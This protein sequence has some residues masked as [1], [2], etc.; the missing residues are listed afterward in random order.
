MRAL[1]PVVLA[2][3]IAAPAQAA[4]VGHRVERLT[5][6]GAATGEARD[7]PVHLWYPADATSA[8]ARPLTTYTSA[9]NGRPVIGGKTPLSW[10]ID[11]ELA[12]EGATVDP[13]GAP[14]RVV[15]F[16]HGSV[17]DPIDYAHTLE[18]VAAAGFIVAAPYH[19]NNSQEDVRIDFANNNGA[20]PRIPC[21]DGRPSP[22]SRPD[23][24]LSIADRVHDISAIIDALPTWFGA[25][26]D[27]AKV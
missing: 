7:I 17:N 4:P 8:V 2:L 25:R 9:L 3:A 13:A 23:V 5:V 20:S 18:G 21:N 1:A 26:A 22:C 27:L 15:V 16:S 14:F 6:A 11:A 10:R 24:A 19:T 12:R